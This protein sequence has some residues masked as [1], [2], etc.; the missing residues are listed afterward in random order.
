MTLPFAFVAV[1][2]A[3][4]PEPGTTNDPVISAPAILAIDTI[5]DIR[6]TRGD[7]TLVPVTLSVA[8]G[9]H[10]Q[11]N[12]AGGEFLIPLEMQLDPVEGLV[13]GEATYPQAVPYRLANSED[14]LQTYEGTFSVGVPVAALEVGTFGVN[15]RVRYQACDAKRCLFPS[16]IP[17]TF[18]ISAQGKLEKEL[19]DD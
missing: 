13:F 14:I 1:L 2:F 7:T 15:G 9:Y 19:D 18:R 5:P 6:V 17:F 4:G 8:A 16:T 3:V 12:P 11:A 10:V